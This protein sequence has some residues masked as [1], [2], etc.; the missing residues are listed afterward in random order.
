M[1]TDLSETGLD[2]PDGVAVDWV[3]KRVYWSDAGRKAISSSM[4]NGSDQRIVIHEGLDE[5]RAIALLPCQKWV[6]TR[7]QESFPVHVLRVLCCAVH[8]PLL[9]RIFLRDNDFCCVTFCTLEYPGATVL[10]ERPRW[11]GIDSSRHSAFVAQDQ[12]AYSFVGLPGWVVGYP[13]SYSSSSSSHPLILLLSLLSVHPAGCHFLF[14]D[15][16]CVPESAGECSGRIGESDPASR[17]RTLT[18][19]TNTLWSRRAWAGLM[20]WP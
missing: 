16:R 15:W 18:A 10:F 20:V 13:G 8:C 11:A 4:F 3:F 6:F 5:P 1:W 2:N 14:S 7:S 9:R 19:A 12:S 17:L